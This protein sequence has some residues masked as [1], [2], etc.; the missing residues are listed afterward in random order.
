MKNQGVGRCRPHADIFPPR[1]HFYSMHTADD[2][3]YWKLAQ[4]HSHDVLATTVLQTCVRY[5][6]ADTK[7][8]FCAI[9]ESLKGDRTI[10]RKTPEQRNGHLLHRPALAIHLGQR[11]VL[12]C[13]SGRALL[14]QLHRSQAQERQVHRQHG[15]E[16]VGAGFLNSAPTFQPPGTPPAIIHHIMLFDPYPPFRPRDFVFKIA[17]TPNELDG[18][19][20]LRRAVCCEEQHVFQSGDDRDAID[21]HA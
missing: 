13:R 7:C 9:G 4:L 3:P 17:S 10:A 14:G 5:G 6:N 2:I 20:A 15:A 8:Q 1:P 18:Y 19:W 11:S 16:P 12:R 21:D